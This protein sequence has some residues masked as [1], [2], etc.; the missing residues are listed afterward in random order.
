MNLVAKIVKK[1]RVMWDVLRLKIGGDNCSHAL[2]EPYSGVGCCF[3][4]E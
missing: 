2:N 4:E 3:F 1:K